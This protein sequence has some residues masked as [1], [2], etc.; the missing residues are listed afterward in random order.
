LTDN[1][2][3]RWIALRDHNR[4]DCAGMRR[5]SRQAAR[6]LA[7]DEAVGDAVSRGPS[8]LSRRAILPGT[9]WL[10]SMGRRRTHGGRVQIKAADDKQPQIDE[11]NALAARPDVDAA[12]R[13]Q[14]ETEIRT[15]RAGAAGERDAAYEIEFHFGAEP[16]RMTIHDLRLEVDGRVAQIDHLIIDRVLTIWV[17]ESKHFSEGV[18]VD[19]LG[20]WTGFS[21]RRPYGT[22]SPIEQNR[23]HIAVLSD[24]FGKRL[25]EPVKRLGFTIHPE[26]RSLILVSK[27]AR[28]TRPKTKAGRARVEGLDMVIK[29]DQLMQVISA[30]S[31]AR[32]LKVAPRI[33]GTDT[34]ERVARQLVALHRPLS[35]DW[36]ARFGVGATPAAAPIL[37]PSPTK[38]T[39][40]DQVSVAACHS[41]GRGV[42]AKVVQY[43]VDQADRFAG[44]IL[45]YTC[46]RQVRRA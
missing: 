22:G 7:A 8:R 19:D 14:I 17:C 16:N 44:R 12:T 18:A 30:A 37:E 35:V 43:C 31:E 23:K 42:S 28:I 10:A 46:Q 45:C 38:A 1:Q 27:D 40:P 2:R 33:V 3:R 13:R 5:V 39:E 6:E 34:I 9:R 4:H 26:L 11:L 36:A 29:V 20:E 21:G 15:I 25:V 24:V 41:C 32:G